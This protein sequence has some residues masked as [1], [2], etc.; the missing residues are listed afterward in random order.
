MG[1][2]PGRECHVGDATIAIPALDLRRSIFAKR[3]GGRC[4]LI[5]IFREGHAPAGLEKTAY[6]PWQLLQ[7][8]RSVT[9]STER[10]KKKSSLYTVEGSPGSCFGNVEWP[11]FPHTGGRW[12]KTSERIES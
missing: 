10:S 9:K 11:L 4:I 8:G 12:A 2:A 7:P 6:E 1:Y 3:N 5:F